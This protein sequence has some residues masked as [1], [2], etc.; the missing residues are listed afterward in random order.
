VNEPVICSAKGCRAAAAYVIVWN[1][2]R[3][4]PPEREKTWAACSEHRESL[5]AHLDV[6]GFLRRV[7]P[8]SAG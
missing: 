5:S 6:R 7:D 8:L 4:H 1:N 3:I 2:P